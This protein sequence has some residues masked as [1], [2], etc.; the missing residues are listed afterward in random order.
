MDDQGIVPVMKSSEYLAVPSHLSLKPASK[1]VEFDWERA[2]RILRKNWRLSLAFVLVVFSLSVLIAFKSPDVYEPIARLEIDPPGS[3]TF[4]LKDLLN[5]SSTDQDYLETQIQI[6][7]SDELAIDVIRNLRLDRNP[8]IVGTKALNEYNQPSEQENQSPTQLTRLENLALRA[9]KT[10]LSVSRVRN[11]R[12]VGVSFLSRDATLSSQVTN[13]LVNIFIDRN[14]RTRYETT[15]RASEWLSGQLAD[16]RQKVEN[17]NKVL[18]DYQ[19]ANGIVYSDEKDN[20]V[21]QKVTQLN[22]E[23][24]QAQADR[25]QLEAY[26][27]M[28]QAGNADSLLQIRN[29]VLLQNLVQRYVEARVQLAQGMAVYGE[30][31]PNTKKLR[32]QVKELQAQVNA[33]RQRIIHEVRTDYQATS[34]KE[35]LLAEAL[36]EVQDLAGA[37]NEKMIRYNFLKN[38]AQTNSGLYNAL[39][40][41]LK[42][43]GISAGLKS[44]NIRVVDAA[45]ILDRPTGPLR[46]RNILIGLFIGLLGGVALAFLREAVDNT[47]H[48]PDDLKDTIDLPSLAMFPTVTGT[49]GRGRRSQIASGIRG[50]LVKGTAP[51]GEHSVRKFVLTEPRSPAAEA[52]RSLRTSLMFS[53]PGKPPRVILIVSGSPYEG[54]STIAVNLAITC[55]QHAHVC[56]LDADLRNPVVARTFGLSPQNGLTNILTGGA[57]LEDVLLKVPGIENLHV[58][59]VGPRP[60]NPGEL[61]ASDQ[62][63]ELIQNLRERFDFVIIDTPP[64]IPFADSRG[65]SPVT[66]AV[67]VVAR[68]GYTTRRSILRT[69]EILMDHRA[70]ALGIV[71]NG[72]DVS[73][74]DYEYYMYGYSG[75]YGHHYG[76]GYYDYYSE[77]IQEEKEEDL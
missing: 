58:L 13:T 19:R 6:L 12:L 45:R 28:I 75:R 16:L 7:Q 31:N 57:R 76:K 3:E 32:S 40:A 26:L 71:L 9:F 73:S 21:T 70:T 27:K 68:V 25:I 43:A 22:H 4:S 23:L 41:R 46:L 54:K 50:L 72:V 63:R 67:I 56:L 39:L 59:P 38:D 15:M 69:L 2:V 66:D 11:S 60:P 17:A 49:N 33:E 14:Y 8:K 30:N 18:V 20:A 35:Q 61:I 44:S 55:A 36:K 74:P 24:T 52:V 5:L 1:K 48:T 77:K 65:L 29:N 37:M 51:G 42:E 34:A 47:V 10:R 64:L 53:R 62:M